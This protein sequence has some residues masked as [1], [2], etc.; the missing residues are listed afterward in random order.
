MTLQETTAKIGP[1][2]VMALEIALQLV[3]GHKDNA[4]KGLVALSLMIA[5]DHERQF[6]ATIYDQICGDLGRNDALEKY[7]AVSTRH[8]PAAKAMVKAILP[9]VHAAAQKAIAQ[10]ARVR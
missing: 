5:V 1:N 4:Q 3:Q 9:A 8:V 10:T 6:A 2:N 7:K